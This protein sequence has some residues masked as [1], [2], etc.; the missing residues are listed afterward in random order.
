M[1]TPRTYLTC[2]PLSARRCAPVA[3]SVAGQCPDQRGNRL[4]ASQLKAG[5]RRRLWR[6][7]ASFFVMAIV[8]LAASGCD[9][10]KTYDIGSLFPATANKCAKYNGDID[11]EGPLGHCWVT[12]NDCLRAVQDW[13]TAMQGIPR[14]ISFRCD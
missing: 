5:T 11:G 2:S 7:L 13:N 14:S 10:G 12:K 6:S 3:D 8:M 4:C 1:L 9:S